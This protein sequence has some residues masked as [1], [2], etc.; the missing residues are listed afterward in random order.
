MNCVRTDIKEFQELLE[1]TKLPSLLLE[2]RIAKWQE[3]N[4]LDKFPTSD[5][6]LVR[7]GVKELFEFNPELANEVYE[8]L[9]Y[10]TSITQDNKSYYRG[11][12]EEPTI[13]KNGNLVLYAKEDGL[14]K[15]AGLKSKGVSMTDDLQ[16][17]IEYGNGQLDVAQN[18][19]S[20]T[21]DAERELER[22]SENGYYLI[23]IS[24]NI[25]NEI[26][27]EAGEVKVIGDKIVIPKGQY[28]IEQ[29]IDG[30]NTE[31]TPQQKQQAQQLYSQYLE[32][33]PNGSVEQFK[34]WLDNNQSDIQ[35]QKTSESNSFRQS[36]NKSNTNPILQ[37]DQTNVQ[38]ESLHIDPSFFQ[39]SPSEQE[40]YLTNIFENLQEEEE[41]VESVE[42][43]DVID[44]IFQGSLSEVID[45]MIH[46]MDLSDNTSEILLKILS[47]T[48]AEIEYVSA[49]ELTSTD[50]IMEYDHGRNV[51][52]VSLERLKEYSP[53]EISIT[54]LHEMVH[55]I[56]VE[57][58]RNPKTFE[59]KDLVDLIESFINDNKDL[60]EEWGMSS[61]FEFVAELYS[62][63]EFRDKVKEASK[64]K[65]WSDFINAIRRLL[66]LP[67][68]R[69][70]N[71]LVEK[72]IEFVDNAES[73]ET[74]FNQIFERKSTEKESKY[75]NLTSY[76][77]IVYEEI[78]DKV[79]QVADRIRASQKFKSQEDKKEYLEN[80]EKLIEFLEEH[81]ETGQWLGVL[82]YTK[83]F[84]KT[85]QQVNNLLEKITP[86]DIE[87]GDLGALLHRYEEY[88]AA[89]DLLEDMKGL[90]DFANRKSDELSE[91]E[92]EDVKEIGDFLRSARIVK[93]G[94][95]SKI[96]HIKKRQLVKFY[97]NP[98]YNT[99]V[100]TNWR[101]LLSNE[102]KNL[103]EEERE[104]I[105]E[106]EYISQKLNGE[107][108]QDYE[109]DLKS[110]AEK[111]VYDPLIDISWTARHLYDPFNTNQP[112]IQILTNFIGEIRQR[113][114]ER[115]REKSF[116]IDELHKKLIKEKGN[117]KP[118]ALFKNL[119]QQDKDGNYFLKGE[120]DI[121]F[122][123]AYREEY[124]PIL[125]SIQ[126][127]YKLF[128]NKFSEETAAELNKLRIKKSTWEKKYLK[129]DK[130][131][132]K[133]EFKTDLSALSPAE[134]QILEE[135][136]NI[137]KGSHDKTEG[138]V[139]LIRN[140]SFKRGKKRN[141]IEF[142]KLPA[143]NKTDIERRIEADAK[144]II[145]DKTED[146][147]TIRTDDVGY[148]KEAITAKG[149]PV[150]EIPI[151]FRGNLDP[152]QQSLDLASMYKMEFWNGEQF[153]ESTQ[154][155]Y[156]AHMILDVVGSN[157]FLKKSRG[158]PRL[159]QNA[160]A[161][162]QPNQKVEGT[163]TNTYHRIQGLIERNFG[164]IT[165]YYAGKFL[166]KD[167]NK[168]I[169]NVQAMTGVL[170]MS[171]NAAAGVANLFNGF[172]NLIMEAVG[173]NIVGRKH[174][175][176]AESKY[177]L[178]L[179]NGEI[180][181]DLTNPVKKSFINQ[182]NEYF[183]V[184][185]GL[186]PEQQ[187][188][189]RNNFMRKFASL[190]MLNWM[191][192]S[193]EHMLHSI[194]N[195]AILDSIKVMNKDGKYINK[196]GEVVSEENA[197][198]LLDMFYLDKNGHLAVHE[199]VGKTKYNLTIDFQE[200]GK[201]HIKNLIKK[202]IFDIYGVYDTNFKNEL[203]KLWGGKL[204]MTFKNFFL[205]LFNYRFAGIEYSHLPLE[206]REDWQK[207][208]STADQEYIE[209]IYTT[210][211]HTVVIPIFKGFKIAL[212]K[213][214]Y[215]KLTDYQKA[216]L[217]KALFE[218]AMT[219][220]L[221]PAIGLLLAAM[222]GDDD[223]KLWFAI[224]INRRLTAELAQF[225]NPVEATKLLTNP[226]ASA[227]FVRDAIGL[228]LEIIRPWRWDER[229]GDGELRIRK[230]FKRVV[231][232]WNQ[233]EKNYRQLY[234]IQFNH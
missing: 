234:N 174:L 119:Y 118:S 154:G 220:V 201:V 202:K 114:V 103:P 142:F 17:A 22:L 91:K 72:V 31:I 140:V 98:L 55:S 217:R 229:A 155:K 36:L 45:N 93:E 134:R 156:T 189:L 116:T 106:T 99:Q 145:K 101:I 26:V 233:L 65:W 12:T 146:L 216:N 206:E 61:T 218:F 182:L 195:M 120:Y 70:Y 215:N 214:N 200:G 230:R 15:K 184:F 78:Q 166:G 144:G 19:A 222:D 203:S 94:I 80:I 90:L 196:Q 108:K 199:A 84:L 143:I 107:Y 23:Q 60:S 190:G 126:E 213:E 224:Y 165:T 129:E 37:D 33:N 47:K 176:K 39:K 9:G 207:F 57:S 164:G 67:Y 141:D 43:E 163:S 131:T 135:F 172:S 153:K 46:H 69:N 187:S 97:S 25:S 18:L 212:I 147:F 121:T 96:L 152:S 30:V 133:D 208:Y 223:D 53:A 204:L 181:S 167:V 161:K 64:T 21:Y 113:I 20:E 41:V 5:E 16:S 149:R 170:G 136:I 32:Q 10:K 110:S 68:K 75:A 92:L 117:K 158:V 7:S 148:A 102:Y 87:N 76:L 180:L 49:S 82:E 132:P 210:F 54:L 74:T 100:T 66:G 232:I 197:A 77:N 193:G 40:E 38:L 205:S 13:D 95:D 73:S 6:V 157:D 178:A 209:G 123:D 192:D 109:A 24:K 28:K 2:M 11:Q 52:K 59:Q 4:G 29:V 171:F 88:L 225:R 8:A 183:D 51:I 173:N 151:Y 62:N 3:Q 139:S 122:Y 198:S 85:T 130:L 138:R 48:N 50:T 14:Y 112:I 71:N 58:L 44:S 191:N 111:L 186:M 63:P 188:S 179:A 177:M 227:K 228:S 185:G 89:Y 175:M 86:Q 83:L 219:N 124:L 56:T 194:L 162:R 221:L 150:A 34:S 231:P 226:I 160:F 127:I 125:Q 1:T 35:Y 79:G 105:S 128:G 159:L 211:V 81:H 169:S 42:V 115:S 137:T 27:K 168:M 104:K